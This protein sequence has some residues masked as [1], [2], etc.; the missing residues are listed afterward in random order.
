MDRFVIGQGA[1]R[2]PERAE[3]L[4]R[5][6]PTL[7]RPVQPGNRGRVSGV[8]VGVDDT[9]RL[10]DPLKRRQSENGIPPELSFVLTFTT[11]GLCGS[12]GSPRSR[13]LCARRPKTNGNAGWR[14]PCA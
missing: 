6:D 5:L 3:M 11:L 12:Y 2:T 10:L 7:D 9:R 14:G 1:P 8:L 4:T 13:Q